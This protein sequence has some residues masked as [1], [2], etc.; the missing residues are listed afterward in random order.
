MASGR[1]NRGQLRASQADREQVIDVLKTAFVQGRLAKHELDARVGQAF[2]SRTYAELAVITAD[3]PTGLVGTQPPRKSAPAK[4]QPQKTTDINPAV[5]ALIT[6]MSALT[7]GLWAVLIG[8]KI[9]DDGAKMMVLFLLIL[10]FTDI[11]MLILAGVVIRE[12][13]HQKHS[14]HQ[15]PPSAPTAR[16]QASRRQVPGA[17]AQQLP[18][19]NPG[20]QLTAE[21]QRSV[22]PGGNRS[23]RGNRS[24]GAVS[25]AS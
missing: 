12:S 24:L 15:L 23:A 11:G 6:G 16:G 2:V 18:Q 17:S 4:A 5:V 1:A 9:N 19:A 21:A 10:T 14:G 20:R 13:H 8:H 7:A 3:L 25:A 22:P